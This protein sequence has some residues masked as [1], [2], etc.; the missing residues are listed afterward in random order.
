MLFGLLKMDLANKICNNAEMDNNTQS[1]SEIKLIIL[2][3]DGVL[4]FDS[5]NYIKSPEEW[6]PIPG[7]AEAVK[8]LKDAGYFVAVATNQSGVGRGYYS[9]AVLEAIHQKMHAYLAKAGTAVD[10]I[11]YCPHTPDNVCACRKPKS[12]MLKDLM[13]KFAVKPEETI[14]VGDALRDLQAAWG[15]HC[16]AVLVRSGKGFKTLAEHPEK[17]HGTLA[18][19]DLAA[20]AKHLIQKN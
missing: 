17:L 13:A 16:T 5:D 6:R 11:A 18:F 14:M 1:Q 3:R 10:A 8:L 7:S 9:E 15:V 20:F 4:N 12:G 19:D 2:D